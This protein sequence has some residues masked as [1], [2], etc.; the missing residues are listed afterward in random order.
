MTY[1][2][3]IMTLVKLTFH[4]FEKSYSLSMTLGINFF[5]SL[6]M[7][8][9]VKGKE[10]EGEEKKGGVRR[11]GLSH[12]IQRAQILKHRK[13]LLKNTVFNVQLDFGEAG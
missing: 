11:R 4:S 7:V 9:S 3:F 1:A 13:K 10:R 5:L 8:Y 12:L 6:N 2:L